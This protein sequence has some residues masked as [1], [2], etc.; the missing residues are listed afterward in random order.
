MVEK[1]EAIFFE[2]SVVHRKENSCCKDLSSHM[3]HFCTS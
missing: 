2:D 3:V 1:D